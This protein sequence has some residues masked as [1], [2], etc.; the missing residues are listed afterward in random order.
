MP[1]LTVPVGG[2]CPE[3]AD[4]LTERLGGFGC[5][6]AIV[7]V[8]SPL[9]LSNWTLPVLELTMVLGA[10]LAVGYATYRARRKAD[11]VPLVV[12]VASVVYLLLVEPELYFPTKAG[13]GSSY[14]LF[15][16]NVFTVTFLYDRL[17]LYIVALYVVLPLLAFGIVRSLGVFERR[18]AFVAAVSVGVVHSSLYEVFDQLGP[19]LRWWIWNPDA[20]GNHPFFASVPMDSVT[21]F[22]AVAPIGLAY[23]AYR[24]VAR[25]AQAGESI[26]GW[27]YVGRTLAVGA[28]T[29]V[30]LVIGAI[31]LSVFGG[32]HP[33]LTARAIV[34]GVEFGLIW[35]IGAPALVRTWTELRRERI[36]GAAARHP[37]PLTP[38]PGIVVWI[39]GP[40][41][42]LVMAVLWVTALPAAVDAVHGTTA[43]GT[44]IGNLP[45]AAGCFLAGVVW[46][47]AGSG[48][49]GSA[50]GGLDGLTSAEARDTSTVE[51][52]VPAREDLA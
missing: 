9:E 11:P 37:G 42:L 17:P 27:G 39:F 41:Y 49:R 32:N 33:D 1:I 36:G 38:P 12:I 24:L 6:P 29:P 10:V 3:V 28:L 19:Q 5:G 45:F 43:D 34:L 46:V 2:P 26:S 50:R 8:R 47:V 48:L 15:A 21:L 18:G 35:L 4:R 13:I 31:P 16:H 22:S 25:K 30:T 52:A 40:M 7:D 44:P 51:L 23:F 20:D 14:V